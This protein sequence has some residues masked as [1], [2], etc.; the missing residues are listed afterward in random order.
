MG[1]RPEAASFV[2]KLCGYVALRLCSY[3]TMW[4]YGNM[5]M[6]LCGYVV[7]GCGLLVVVC[8]SNIKP[9]VGEGRESFNID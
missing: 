6:W 1:K 3:V 2:A 8:W 9:I 4:L 5:A 7:V